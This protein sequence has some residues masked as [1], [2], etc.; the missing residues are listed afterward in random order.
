MSNKL[1]NLLLV[2]EINSELG[3]PYSGTDDYGTKFTNLRNSSGL[4]SHVDTL[5]SYTDH[6]YSVQIGMSITYFLSMRSSYSKIVS[7]LINCVTKLYTEFMYPLQK[8][9]HCSDFF[10]GSLNYN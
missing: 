1:I 10:L 7:K 9:Q 5:S 6:A 3:K 2:D 4:Q 8:T